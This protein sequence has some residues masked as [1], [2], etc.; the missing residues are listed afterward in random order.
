L[1][2]SNHVADQARTR[3][4]VFTRSA[5]R[6][7]SAT[8]SG[9]A[10]IVVLVGFGVWMAVGASAGFPRWWELCASVG[11]PFVTLIMLVVIQHTQNHDDAAT[12]L[13][14]DELIRA[15]RGASN[16]MMT[17]EEASPDDLDKI[18]SDFRQQADDAAP[19][20]VEPH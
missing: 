16:R 2:V 3:A 17:L 6:L 18:K 13:K 7:T 5:Q 9:T 20:G 15:T 10:A 14:L 11:V 4:G 8:G 12:Q 1:R 19:D